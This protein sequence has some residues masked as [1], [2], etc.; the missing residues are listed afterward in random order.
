MLCLGVVIHVFRSVFHQDREKMTLV[1]FLNGQ[2]RPKFENGEN[3]EI[4]GD[5]MKIAVFDLQNANTYSV[6]FQ[7]IYLKFCTHVHRTGL[8]TLTCVPFFLKIRKQTLKFLKI[9]RIN[10]FFLKN[11]NFQNFEIRYSSLVE[12]FILNLFLK[13]NQFYLLHY[14]H[15]SVSRK[16]SFL[17]ETGK[18]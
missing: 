4:P 13:T 17:P 1:H 10:Y 6:I 18:T 12:A 11:Q 7:D 16:P 5:S 3:T 2:N 15:D 8:F 9:F 14:L